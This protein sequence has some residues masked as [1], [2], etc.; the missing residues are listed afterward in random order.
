MTPE[1]RRVH[2]RRF[3]LAALRP[4][5]HSFPCR[6]LDSAESS[7]GDASCSNTSTSHII[8]VPAEESGIKSLAFATVHSIWMKA[9]EYLRSEKDIVP[10]PG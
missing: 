2:V 10:A 3:D 5:Q 1:Q 4:L 6:S 7:L 8:S 9:E